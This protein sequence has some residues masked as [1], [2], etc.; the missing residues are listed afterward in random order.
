[1]KIYFCFLLFFFSSGIE[2]FA[3]SGAGSGT[4]DSPYLVSTASQFDEVRNNLTAYYR[5]TADIDLSAYS[6]WSKIGSSP[7]VAFSGT[8]DGNGHIITGLTITSTTSQYNG[9][10]GVI[11]STGTIMNLG[12]TGANISGSVLYLGILAGYNFGGTIQNCFSSGTVSTSSNYAGGLIGVSV[13]TESKCYSTANVTATGTSS[14]Y[15]GGLIGAGQNSTGSIS[16]CYSTGNVSNSNTANTSSYTGGFIGVTSHTI[17]DCYSTGSVISS[18]GRTGGFIGG[19]YTGTPTINNCY[20]TGFVSGTTRGGFVGYGAVGTFSNCFFDRETAGTSAADGDGAPPAGITS[21]TTMEMMASSTYTIAG[22]DF[23][24]IWETVGVNYP[25]LR[26]NPDAT[27]PVELASFTALVVG[28]NVTLNWQTA[29][30]VN[31]NGFEIQRSSALPASSWEIIGYS[32]GHGNSYSPQNYSFVDRGV[33]SGEV[34]YRL[35]QIDN[36]GSYKYS[37]E[38]LVNCGMPAEFRLA[39]NYP[40]PFNPSTIISYQLPEAVHVVLKIYDMM[41]KEAATLINGR[42]EAGMY[43]VSFDASKLAT[44]VYIAKLTAG[45]YAK[46]IKMNLIK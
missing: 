33:Q 35:K 14:S 39:Q 30:E 27:L 22:W 8:Y 20:S 13:G 4:S 2:L 41:G 6:N 18:S 15:I 12:I 7:T 44:G 16:E 17:S 45:K 1:M 9:L 28:R 5:Q 36:D 38:V 43:N 42:Q 25:R 37:S 40:N 32:Q 19:T 10:F 11:K 34:K 24:N 46:S 26:A 21:R 3:F 31:N 29:T 23:F